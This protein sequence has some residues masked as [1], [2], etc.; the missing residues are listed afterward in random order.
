MENSNQYFNELGAYNQ[1]KIS[2]YAKLNIAAGVSVNSFASIEVADNA[3][4]MIEEGVFFNDYCSL[5]CHQKISI[6]AY[7]M[8]GDGVRLFDNN[9]KYSPYHIEQNKF[10]TG[11]I[12]IGKNC[13]IGANTVI[14][15]G[16]TIGDNVIIGAGCTI[17]KDIPA[18][19]LVT[20]GGNISLRQMEKFTKHAFVL[21]MSDHLIHIEHLLQALPDLAIHIAAPCE[22]SDRLNALAQYE[23]CYLYPALVRRDLQEDLLKRA[24]ILLDIND[25][26]E[27]DQIISRAKAQDKLV[28]SFDNVV[29]NKELSDVV[30][31]EDDVDGMIKT[32]KEF[33][34]Q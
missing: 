13:W 5:R 3:E 9:H 28:L 15:K 8:F 34:N 10:T 33:Y 7:T 27:I 12:T 19:S 11:A 6:G 25:W 2:E 1:F 16:V 14:L 30:F 17:Y 21:T 23:N 31:S 22:V 29:K 26:F 18:H 4:L 24:D 32:I 20:S